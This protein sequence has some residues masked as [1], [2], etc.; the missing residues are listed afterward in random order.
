MA[1]EENLKMVNWNESFTLS[2][3]SPNLSFKASLNIVERLFDKHRPR[4]SSPKQ[5][6]KNKIETMDNA[7]RFKFCKN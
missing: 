4:N 2:E 7:S 5:N 3:E 1:F 6:I